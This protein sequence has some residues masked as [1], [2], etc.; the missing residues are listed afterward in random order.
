MKTLKLVL[1][2]CVF[3]F[4]KTSVSQQGIQNNKS[5]ADSLI[6]EGDISGALVEYQ[7]IYFQNPTDQ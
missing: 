4:G 5:T 7:K 1:F 6:D 2:I 3:T